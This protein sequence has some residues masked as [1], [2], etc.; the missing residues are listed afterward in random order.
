MDQQPYLY[1][2][3]I[4][5]HKKYNPAYGDDRICKCGHPY[6]RHFDT[7]DNMDP[8]GCKYCNCYDFVERDWMRDKPD[9][10]WYYA[11]DAKTI[12][13]AKITQMDDQWAW[14]DNGMCIMLACLSETEEQA[15]R[16]IFAVFK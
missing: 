1:E 10:L 16:E 6:Y 9:K 7:Y 15:S 5:I 8:C 11:V 14:L 2:Q 13:S 12:E 4:I 3:E